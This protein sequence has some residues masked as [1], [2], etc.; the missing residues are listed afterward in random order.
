GESQR[1]SVRET[2]STLGFNEAISFSFY[3]S[4]KDAL[5]RDADTQTISLL[6]PI[7]ENLDQMR[8]SLLPGLLDAVQHNFNHGTRNVNLF[9]LGRC[10]NFAGQVIHEREMLAIVMTGQAAET[11]WQRQNEM[12]DFYS[13]KGV[14]EAMFEKLGF[15]DYKF[16]R[17]SSLFLH[18]GQSAEI[19]AGTTDSTDSFGPFGRL[20][21]RIATE[22]KLKQPVYIAEVAFNKLIESR[23][24]ATR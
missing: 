12:V 18:P 11:D 8:T 1:R 22:F 9:E 17:S 5:F 2:L 7:I 13:I 24:A 23:P 20:H 14:I 21:P 16:V 6:N 10:F 4:S 19:Y 15:R 3:D